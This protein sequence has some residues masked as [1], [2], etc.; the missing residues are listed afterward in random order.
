MA[1]LFPL[2]LLHA[3]LLCRVLSASEECTEGDCSNGHGKFNY[4]VNGSTYDGEWKDD[5]KHGFGIFIWGE[6]GDRYEGDFLHDKSS[7]LGVF[8]VKDGSRYEGTSE[9]QSKS[10]CRGMWHI[11]AWN[12]RSSMPNFKSPSSLLTRS[13]SGTVTPPPRSH[14][15]T[16]TTNA[17]TTYTTGDYKHDRPHGYGCFTADDG[18][19]YEGQ[20]VRGHMHG[21]GVQYI[22][23][24][25]K[26]QAAERF[27]GKFKK[28]S[29][30]GYGVY[31]FSNGDTYE[32][33]WE[34]AIVGKNTST[35]E[36]DASK[37]ARRNAKS[38][39]EAAKKAKRQ[40]KRARG[41][42][43][44]KR[45]NVEWEKGWDEL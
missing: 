43:Q 41:R 22:V 8:T 37:K 36:S 26:G 40:R 30:A 29:M 44:E 4:G 38:A 28:G 32:G 12:G 16:T 3:L 6:S 31:H 23:S 19:R 34:D 15:T 20:Y 42:V 27:E 2:L 25:Q 17:P 7:G 24:N 9:R 1:G 21:Y 33:L 35:T 11:C 18:N 13:A 14:P 45:E 39:V 10:F 5:Q